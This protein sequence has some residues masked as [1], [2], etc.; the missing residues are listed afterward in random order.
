[1]QLL[2]VRI[3][4]LRVS[5]SR[6]SGGGTERHARF[7]T[8]H[9][10]RNLPERGRARE[11]GDDASF[12]CFTTAIVSGG[13]DFGRRGDEG[14]GGDSVN[15]A[16]GRGTRLL[17]R[18]ARG[19]AARKAGAPR[20]T[21]P[22]PYS[23]EVTY[24]AFSSSPISFHLIE[25]DVAQRADARV[26]VRLLDHAG[27]LLARKQ[28]VRILRD[29]RTPPRGSLD[30]GRRGRSPEAGR[31]PRGA[32]GLGGRV[33]PRLA[34]SRARGRVRRWARTEK[35]ERRRDASR[36]GDRRSSGAL[37]VVIHTRVFIPVASR[38]AQ[39]GRAPRRFGSVLGRANWKAPTAAAGAHAPDAR[40]ASEAALP[41]PSRVAPRATPARPFGART[42]SRRLGAPAAAAARIESEK[43]KKLKRPVYYRPRAL[44]GAPPARD[45]SK[46]TF[47]RRP[48]RPLPPAAA[49]GVR[50]LLLR[51]P[52]SSSS[53]AGY[54]SS[55]ASSTRATRT[56]TS[57]TSTAIPRRATGEHVVFWPIASAKVA[58][59]GYD[60]RFFDDDWDEADGGGRHGG[61]L[62]GAVRGGAVAVRHR[63]LGVEGDG[64]LVRR[65]WRRRPRRRS[66]RGGEVRSSQLRRRRPRATRRAG[67]PDDA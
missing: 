17:R 2:L 59:D 18:L 22:C 4:L 64:Q 30:E 38:C 67:R 41:A 65:S 42:A 36:N 25:E 29:R 45:R 15:A 23:T 47:Q 8:P 52:S 5:G 31:G 50:R 40:E 13:E 54:R 46:V 56:A 43:K 27:A 11:R 3:D 32:R 53:S 61:R 44:T 19:L 66:R 62:L 10:A 6:D 48:R 14:L 37:I 60:E 51:G 16:R 28:H 9:L 55:S 39:A 12:S 20:R 26:R 24:G 34:R 33:R 63:G 35:G 7:T 1:M 49:P 58:C 57:S 21:P